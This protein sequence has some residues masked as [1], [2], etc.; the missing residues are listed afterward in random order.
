ML[1][2]SVGALALLM[3]L[4]FATATPVGAAAANYRNPVDILIPGGGR[5]KSCADPS[6]IQGQ[7]PGDTAWYMYCTTDPLNNDDK[8]GSDYNF[9]LIP[10]MRSMDLVHWTY[11][12]DAFTARPTW[13]EPNAGLWA[14][15]VKYFDGL[16]HLYVVV[17]D[18][19]P[20]VSGDTPDCHDDNAIGVATSASPV[21]PWTFTDDPVVEPRR[22]FPQPEQHACD[23]AWFWDFDPDVITEHEGTQKYIY[24]GSYFGGVQVRPLSADGLTT[25]PATAVQITLPNRYE[26]SEVIYHDGYYYY[27]GSATDC[28]RGPLTGYSVFVGRSTSPTGPFE[29]R[30]GVSLLNGRVG[31]SVF[32]TMNGNRWVGPGH[33]TTFEDH[34]GQWWS[35]YHAVDRNRPYFGGAT[36]FTRRPVLLDPVDWVNGWPTVRGGRWVSAQKMPVPAAQPGDQ[37]LYQ[38]VGP[39]KHV[40]RAVLDEDNFDGTS[41]GAG[42]SWVREPAA[43]T[44]SVA[45]GEFHMDTQNAD[46]HV[47]DHNASVLLR[48]LPDGNWMIETKV[49]VNLPAEGCCFNFVQAGMLVYGDDDNYLKLAHVSI[50]ETRQIEWAKELSPVPDGYPRY[51]N[52]VVTAPGEWTWLR[53]ARYPQDGHINYQA[54]VSRDGVN[55]NRGGVWTHDLDTPQL[56]LFAMGGSGFQ[57]DFDYIKVYRIRVR[58]TSPV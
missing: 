11:V 19:K 34:D 5:V 17:T 6:V 57:A 28:C 23:Y 39:I 7:T 22:A 50:W 31:G 35:F 55:W 18:V 49:R 25:E 10:T 8:T 2:A 14:P 30:D 13:A 12:R 45:D 24:Y 33:Q 41:L 51:G 21:G 1:R 16:Y 40:I 38:P 47:D 56:G 54:Y 42:W 15:E 9:H 29:D 48:D 3:A 44:W 37:S 53:I 36:G 27:L 46:L 32:L 26:G 4:S 58:N 20:E 43:D 52:T